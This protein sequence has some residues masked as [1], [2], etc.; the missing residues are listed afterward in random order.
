M[1]FE[2][3]SPE[4]WILNQTLAL[5]DFTRFN[6]PIPV[7]RKHAVQ[8]TW[9]PAM[10]RARRASETCLILCAFALLGARKSIPCV[11][12][13]W[14]SW[15]AC[16]KTVLSSSPFRLRDPSRTRPTKRILFPVFFWG[17]ACSR[18]VASRA[19][20]VESLVLWAPEKASFVSSVFWA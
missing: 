18:T 12:C 5:A 7:H 16:D 8:I 1:E 15:G 17:R 6:H 2:R 3:E 14:A 13:F 10:S 11:Q 19:R 20:D 9:E 4:T